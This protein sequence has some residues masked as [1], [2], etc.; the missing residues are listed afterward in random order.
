LCSQRGQVLL[1]GHR[2]G[3]GPE[4]LRAQFAMV[5]QD[6]V[7]F[8]DSIAANVALGAGCGSQRV[9][10]CL[11]AANLA[12]VEALPQG[13]HTVVGHNATSCRAA[14]ASAWPLRA[15]CTRMPRS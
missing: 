15:R 14:S 4:S 3:L 5:S 6:V 11:A 10:E 1:D 12:Y 13:M 2:A 8:N 7:M 9:H